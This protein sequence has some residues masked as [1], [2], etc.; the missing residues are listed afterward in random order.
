M[1]PSHCP[2]KHL[3][4]HRSS[5]R[6]ALIILPREGIVPINN[7][8]GGGGVGSSDSNDNDNDDEEALSPAHCVHRFDST[9]CT[10]AN[11]GLPYNLLAREGCK[12]FSN[13]ELK[14]AYTTPNF[15]CQA[16]V[17]I[18]EYVPSTRKDFWKIF[19]TILNYWTNFT[20]DLQRINKCNSILYPTRTS[21]LDI[22]F[23]INEASEYDF[24]MLRPVSF[25]QDIQDMA[26]GVSHLVF[27]ILTNALKNVSSQLKSFDTSVTF[28]KCRPDNMNCEIIYA[29]KFGTSKEEITPFFKCRFKDLSVDPHTKHW[30][31]L[32]KSLFGQ[33]NAYVHS[34]CC[35]RNVDM[36]TSSW[37][38]FVFEFVNDRLN[39]A[40]HVEDNLVQEIWASLHSSSSSTQSTR[41]SYRDNI[42]NITR[43][44]SRWLTECQTIISNIKRQGHKPQSK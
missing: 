36:Y 44:H 41:R 30:F 2:W 39:R 37:L 6:C 17:H 34:V 27:T 26:I 28:K 38:K 32:T 8:S 9:T 11:D 16:V 42:N 29:K 14:C 20:L 43:F 3:H 7:S 23:Q 18:M 13:F 5:S 4:I 19:Y 10:L 15:N 21:L 12:D 35:A 40:T 33:H 25:I 24:I 22:V 31:L 1:S